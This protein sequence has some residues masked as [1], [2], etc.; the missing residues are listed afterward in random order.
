VNALYFIIAIAAI[1]VVTFLYRKLTGVVAKLINRKLMSKKDYQAELAL[2]NRSFHYTTGKTIDEIK[3]SLRE[4]VLGPDTEFDGLTV[5]GETD[6]AIAYGFTGVF[7]ALARSNANAKF[8]FIGSVGISQTPQLTAVV[9]KFTD[10][11]TTSGVAREVTEMERLKYRVD[12]ALKA[13]DP[14][15]VCTEKVA[16]KK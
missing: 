13:I 2:T 10:W 4:H 9:F 1:V 6:D 16:T 12:E 7:G 5:A 11:V 14:N 3:Q 8:D 15:V